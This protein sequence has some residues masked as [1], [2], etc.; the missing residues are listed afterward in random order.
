MEHKLQHAKGELHKIVNTRVFAKGNQ[1]IFELDH[2][3]RQ[4]R[5]IK[6]NIYTME[7]LLTGKIH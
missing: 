3:I 5:M 4:S 6:D 7:Q 1:A 2:S